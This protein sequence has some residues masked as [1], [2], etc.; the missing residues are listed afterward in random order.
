MQ[1]SDSYK[2]RLK[3]IRVQILGALGVVYPRGIQAQELFNRA[4]SC[5]TSAELIGVLRVMIAREE[6]CQSIQ[7]NQLQ[8]YQLT[9]KQANLSTI[10]ARAVPAKRA[11]PAME[12]GYGEVLGLV[13]QIIFNSPDPISG[14]A[15]AAQMGRPVQRTI[16]TL[17][18]RGEIEL[19]MVKGRSHYWRKAGGRRAAEADLVE[20]GK[21]AAAN[22]VAEK[23]IERF[24]NESE[25]DSLL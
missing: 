13:R 11:R 19:A 8:V 5:N 23:L 15:I 10:K 6:I 2:N 12:S 3:K 22:M 24:F 20:M 17:K 21:R 7:L 14:A 1:I 25:I 9:P 18:G 4:S 16:D